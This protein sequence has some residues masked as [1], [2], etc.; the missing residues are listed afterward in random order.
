MHVYGWR[1]RGTVISVLYRSSRFFLS[2]SF[3]IRDFVSFLLPLFDGFL[4]FH[5]GCLCKTTSRRFLHVARKHT[6][7]YIHTPSFSQLFFVCLKHIVLSYHLSNRSNGPHTHN[8]HTQRKKERDSERKRERERE[9]KEWLN[10]N[11]FWFF[12]VGVAAFCG[13]GK[14]KQVSFGFCDP[15][16]QWHEPVET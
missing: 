2:T 15:Q 3:I 8:T 5:L 9:L 7:L 10:F 11:S 1:Y 16:V 6:T 13:R 14:K 4:G 12:L